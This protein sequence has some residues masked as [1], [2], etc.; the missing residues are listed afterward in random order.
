MTVRNLTSEIQKETRD[1]HRRNRAGAT[2]RAGRKAR[3]VSVR[4]MAS[5]A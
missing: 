5:R 4:R 3:P 2:G 1:E